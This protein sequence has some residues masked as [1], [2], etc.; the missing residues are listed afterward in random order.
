MTSTPLPYQPQGAPMVDGERAEPTLPSNVVAL[1]RGD[2]SRGSDDDAAYKELIA[3]I[4]EFK[5]DD[6]ECNHLTPEDFSEGL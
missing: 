2:A 4:A 1:P 5:D 6:T 3:F